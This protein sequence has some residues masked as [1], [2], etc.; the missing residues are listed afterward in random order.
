MPSYIIRRILYFIPTL[1][2]ISVISFAIIQAPPGD[3]VTTLAVQMEARGDQV[4]EDLIDA[5]RARYG[6]GKPLWR[7]YLIWMGNI[8]QGDLGVSMAYNQ[9]VSRVIMDRLPWSLLFSF[10]AFIIVYSIGFPIGFLSAARQYSI[11]DY[12]LTFVGFI[13]LAIPNFMLALILLWGYFEAT[14][15]ALVGIF[16]AEYAMAPWSFGKFFDLLNHL[17]IPAVII[18]TAGTAGLIRNRPRQSA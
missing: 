7:Q 5:L 15:Q 8:L 10:S 3:F 1:F 16:S 4:D 6:L 18:G 2:L 14:G 9:P 11:A 17:W 12:V 13:G